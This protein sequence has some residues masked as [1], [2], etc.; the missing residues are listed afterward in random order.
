MICSNRPIRRL[1]LISNRSRRESKPPPPSPLMTRNGRYKV[2]QRKE[3]NYD[4]NLEASSVKASLFLGSEATSADLSACSC[5]C[6][7]IT[8][9]ASPLAPGTVRIILAGRS[10][11]VFE[12]EREAIIFFRKYVTV[13][14]KDIIQLLSSFS[15][16][17]YTRE[18]NDQKAVDGAL[19]KAIEVVSELNNCLGT[20][21]SLHKEWSRISL[22]S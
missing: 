12:A 16:S 7:W 19:I 2:D 20:R 17:V 11:R 8:D 15:E 1:Q 18:K 9:R 14:M 5:E 4:T 3:L 6:D 13:L 10:I 22:F 21:F